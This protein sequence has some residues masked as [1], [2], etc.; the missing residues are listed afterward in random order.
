MSEKNLE[1][2][3]IAVLCRGNSLHHIDKI[4]VVDEYVLVNRFGDEL[5]DE[6]LAGILE[7]KPLT[8]I[9]SLVPD[10]PELMIQ[11][12]HYKKFNFNRIVLPY[13]Q[14]TAPGVPQNIEGKNG[15][16]PAYVLGEDHK[17]YMYKRE[18]RPDGDT[19]Y[20]Y[21]Y[22]TSGIAGVVHATIDYDK[23]NVFIIGLDFYQAKY[24][25]GFEFQNVKQS[26][27]RG[28]NSDM[29]M[30]FLT[31]FLSKHKDKNFTIV[32]CSDYTCNFEHVNI[33]NI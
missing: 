17:N 8:H 22:P 1:N 2:N 15:S 3:S 9:L 11:R 23:K 13:I 7:D 5:E 19:R 4:P 30:D 28:E 32:T 14:E 18:E 20:A 27:N 25:Y 26:L 12:G 29:M 21:S 16:I 6:K 10:E 31:N 24:A 33:I